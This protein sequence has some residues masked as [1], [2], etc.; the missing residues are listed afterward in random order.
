MVR[1]DAERRVDNAWL[2][3]VAGLVMLL[4]LLTNGRHGF[5]RDELQFLSDARHLDWGFVPYPPFTAFVE[6]IGL[7]VFGLSLVGL[8]LFSVIAQTV[9]VLVAGSMAREFGGG[10][11]AQVTSAFAVAL[12]PLPLFQGTEFQYSSFDYLWW[13]LAAYFAVKLLNTEDQRWWLAIGAAFGFGLMTKYTIVLAIGGLLLGLV[14]TPARRLLLT[15]GFLAG[16]ALALLIFLPNL[17]WQANHGFITFHFLQSIHARDVGEHRAEGFLAGQFYLDAN[18]GAAPLWIG[19]L[20]CLLLSVRY[21]ALAFLYL[22]PFVALYVGKGRFY[23][24][25][26]V[27]PLVIAMGAAAGERWVQGLKRP[28][29][30]TI[31]A[32]LFVVI[33]AAGAYGCAVVVPLASSGPLREFALKNNGDLREEIGWEEMVNTVAGVR[34]SL[35][36]EQQ[37][38]FGV[39][40]GNYGEQG[41]IEML[42]PKYGLPLPISTTNSAWLRGYPTPQPATLVVLGYSQRAAEATFTNCRVVA[43]NGNSEGV[44][45]EESESHPNIFLC[46]A[47]RQPWPEFWREH[48]NFG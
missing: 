16:V 38:S 29:R 21:R 17:T 13:V 3:V 14:V 5:H 31:E 43:Q 48:R 46:G 22:V 30:V 7:E 23:Y 41:A 12:S 28:V 44:K 18:A 24:V 19:G 15:P 47:P 6:R 25:S 26:P 35:P 2:L 27:Y 32:L 40:V 37:Q 8:R 10:R 42:G 33:A 4:H 11:L 9:V 20:I 36:P 39:V 1:N 45:N 34:D